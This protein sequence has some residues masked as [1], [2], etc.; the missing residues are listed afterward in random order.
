MRSAPLALLP[1][2]G[3]V[4]DL[5]AGPGGAEVVYDDGHGKNM[6]GVNVQTGMAG[7][8]TMNCADRQVY[9]CQASQLPDGTKVVDTKENSDS[10]AVIWTADTLYPDG[11]RVV[12][13]EANSSS[14]IGP[15]TRPQPVL[16][17]D[18]LQA[19]AVSP[20]WTPKH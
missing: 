8:L 13:R 7:Q 1:E 10:D 2:G 12:I 17:L 6:F 18:R 15:V 5:N 19:M 9:F 16:G 11:H 3:T 4:S 20:K 14:D